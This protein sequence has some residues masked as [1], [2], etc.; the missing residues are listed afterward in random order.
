[1][2]V[3]ANIMSLGGIAIAIGSM[4]DSSIV[5]VEQTHKKLEDWLAQGSPGDFKD[6]VVGAAK[7]VGPPSFYSLLVIAIA[8]T[9]IFALE[10]QEGRLFKPLAFTKIAA[11][12][13]AAGLSVTLVPALVVLFIR[14]KKFDF[15]PRWLC[16]VAN[17]LIV[18]KIYP[19]DKHPLSRFLRRLYQ[20]VV[21]L[22]RFRYAHGHRAR[23]SCW[24]QYLSTCGS[25]R[26]SCRRRGRCFTCRRRCRASP[27]PKLSGCCKHR[28]SSSNLSGSRA[29]LRQ[30]G[31]R[32]DGDRPRALLDDG[33]GRR[34]QTEGA[35]AEGPAVVFK[36]GAGMATKAAPPRLVRSPEHGRS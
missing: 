36:L 22:L 16:R 29:R 27:L 24:P 19:E 1:M 15:R 10:A 8:F 35:V 25:G 17:K 21:E 2:N 7:E 12:A 14:P 6:V 31:S 13:I 28:T 9:P 18:G 20:P 5:I 3:T 23:S 34:A 11:I 32:R 33:D 30:G 4:V 26:S